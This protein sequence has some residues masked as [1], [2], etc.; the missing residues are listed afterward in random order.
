MSFVRASDAS[1]FFFFNLYCKFLHH[2]QSNMTCLMLACAGE[3]ELKQG[4]EN[5]PVGKGWCENGHSACINGHSAC[6]QVCF[7]CAVT[8]K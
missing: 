2:V 4:S 8:Y 1:F 5:L 3:V 7:S 6:T